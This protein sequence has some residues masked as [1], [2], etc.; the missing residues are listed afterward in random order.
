MF[1]RILSEIDESKF[2]SKLKNDGLIKNNIFAKYFILFA[3]IFLVVLTILGTTLT[4]FVNAYIQNESTKLLKENTQ[5]IVNGIST[6]FGAQDMNDEY[7]LEKAV[8]C[9]SLSIISSSIDADIFVC[10]VEG[11]IILC[12]EKAGQA[13]YFGELPEC[14]LH[15]SRVGDNLLKKVYEGGY[16]GT[17]S[18]NRERAY[19]VGYPVYSNGDIIGSVMATSASTGESLTFAIVRIFM[20]CALVCLMLGTACIWL[21]TRHFVTPL[22][23]M[24]TAA[25]QFAIGDFSYRVKIK[26]DDELAELGKAFNDMANSLDSLESS[27]RS[28]VSNVSHELRTPMTSIGGFIDG[29]L[30]GTIPKDKE[31]YYLGIVSAEIRRLSRLVVAM[32]NMSK[33]ESGSFEMKPTKY[34]I[35]DQ[36]IHILLTFE[37]KIEGKNIEIKGLENLSPTYIVADS[38][39]IYQVI[40][41]IFDN[42]VKFT[43]DG[44]YIE[45]VM[46]ESQSDI[47]VHIKNSGIG[48]K[49]EELSKIFERF[50]K[51]DKSR[52]LDSKGAGLGLYIVKMMV[53]MHAGSIWAVS[54][55][56][57][58]AEFI[59]RLPK[60]YNPIY[61]KETKK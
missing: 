55:N 5:S 26:G 31:K 34:D 56:E 22:R 54:E 46:K 11:N 15:N 52:S 51:V 16:V 49:S 18:V 61:K 10:D 45:V 43:N 21:L 40:Y 44:G 58:T 23:Q 32:L 25:K 9:S 29:I 1:K 19:I 14:S 48:I 39:M 35:S 53:E 36:I 20:V 37:Q 3:T 17:G 59:F 33:I 4:L 47:E 7:T 50:Y 38:D 30:D 8:L 24:S 60:S 12:K 13:P 42:A 27:R 6:T 57:N 41:N 2:V 28:F